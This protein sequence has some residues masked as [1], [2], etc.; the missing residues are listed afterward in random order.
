MDEQKIDKVEKTL[1]KTLS[2]IALS[3]QKVTITLDTICKTLEKL[4]DRMS[5]D[6]YPRSEVDNI[7]LKLES[8][9]KAEVLTVNSKIVHLESEV[10]KNEVSNSQ[11]RKSVIGLIS[12]IVVTVVGAIIRLVVS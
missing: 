7:V 9:N 2:E 12:L 3:N 8:R 11:I 5:R 6:Y 10:E 1:Q 4:E